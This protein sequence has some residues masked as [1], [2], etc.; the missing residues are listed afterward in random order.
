MTRRLPLGAILAAV[1]LAS[2]GA[3]PG[4]SVSIASE[5]VQTV[6]T[7]DVHRTACSAT[8]RDRVV[9]EI[10]LKTVSE[11]PTLTFAG[12]G[13]TTGFRGWIYDLKDGKLSSVPIEEFTVS[14][15]SGSYEPRT[16]KAGGTYE[17]SINADWSFII[18]GGS[19]TRVFRL[20]VGP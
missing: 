5:T 12:G 6:P 20:R 1:V 17:I 19:E 2:C 16:V 15:A 11:R 7:S 4:M 9:G 10:P 13:G 14:G 18:T 3:D 8:V